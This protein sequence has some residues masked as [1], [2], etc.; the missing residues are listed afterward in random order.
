M[1]TTGKG[2]GG[3]SIKLNPNQQNGQPKVIHASLRVLTPK[4]IELTSAE[5]SRVSVIFG[6]LSVVNRAL[7]GFIARWVTKN[8]SELIRVQKQYHD[9]IAAW[10]QKY[11]VSPD[12]EDT[13]RL[14]VERGNPEPVWDDEKKEI[15][16]G[17][18]LKWSGKKDGNGN[19]IEYV[20]VY[21]DKPFNPES[22]VR[23][24]YE[25][26][27]ENL[28]DECEAEEKVLSDEK[29]PLTIQAVF[30]EVA[31]ELTMP[32]SHPNGNPVDLALLYE[33]FII[34]EESVE[35]EN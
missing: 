11:L 10:K 13:N 9:N 22:K 21:T 23:Y 18:K 6:L 26:K 12:D 33:H 20:S 35:N 17:D 14:F 34:E 32:T 30:S 8:N 19:H 2:K 27:D 1:Q 29:F 28:R 3:K 7:P 24:F 31:D 15:I 25:L 16:S 4:K 5:A